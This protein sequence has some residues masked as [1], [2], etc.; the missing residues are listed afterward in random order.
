MCKF[1]NFKQEKFDNNKSQKNI[2]KKNNKMYNKIERMKNMY[3]LIA[4]DLD[5]TLLNSYGE[6]SKEN[7]EA[8]KNAINNG[9]E[10]VIASGRMKGSIISIAEEIGATNYII[11]GNG[12][13]LYDNKNDKILYE[14]FL[15][16]E[17]VLKIIKI[18]EENS[19]YYNIYTENEV[20]AKNL[21]YNVLF[22]NY[23]NSKKVE[24]KQTKINIIE[25]VYKYVEKTNANIVK[26][27]ICDENQAIFNR[28]INKLKQINDIDVLDIEHM[29]RKK[30]MSGTE[31]VNIGYYYTEI[32][33]KNINKW[34][35]IQELIKNLG[36]EEK[37]VIA[38]G[39]NVN[40]KEMVEKAGLGIAIGNSW[41]EKE[42]IGDIFIS[43]NNSNDIAKNITKILQ[44]H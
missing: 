18:C 3:K 35:A 44:K 40:D 32:M 6:V 8:I 12:A 29:S 34:T 23:E 33:N 38:I 42:H 10:V 24:D 14:S 37:E 30:I 11:S 25:D 21:N 26:I 19:I 15:N 20:I 39:D 2:V 43:D 22:Y 13:I 36:I 4:I 5:G 9:I 28:I 41:L 1:L 31:E 27:T 17:K 7:C 16:K